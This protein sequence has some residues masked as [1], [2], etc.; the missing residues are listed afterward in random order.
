MKLGT[1]RG[2]TNKMSSLYQVL[3]ILLVVGLL[4]ALISIVFVSWKNG[5]S[6]MPSSAKVRFAVAAEINRLS[7]GGTI[8]EAGS[9]WGTL[10]LYL[11]RY[12]PSWRIMGIENSPVPLWISKLILRFISKITGAFHDRVSF[13]S[14]DIYSF[15]YKEADI[16]VCYLYPDAMKR[17]SAI[18]NQ[19]LVPDARVIS[20]C[21][22]LPGWQPKH[23]VTCGDLYH[24]KI[25]VY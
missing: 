21:F 8:I 13:K 17:L 3:S 22:A 9:G 14:G 4:A 18:L 12:C 11:A 24:T 15:S 20:V 19:Q 23:V 7:S 6:P 25:Y 5:I 16:I 10:A 2:V 1:C